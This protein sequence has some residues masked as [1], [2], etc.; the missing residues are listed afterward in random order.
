MVLAHKPVNVPAQD[1]PRR[2]KR[3]Q[4]PR[5]AGRRHDGPPPGEAEHEARDGRRRRVAYHGR[6]GRHEN[7]APNNQPAAP[8][9]APALGDGTEPSEYGVRVGEEQDA[10]RGAGQEHDDG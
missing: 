2:R 3:D 4:R 10:G 6:E 1:R 7:H 5:R 9:R 8:Q